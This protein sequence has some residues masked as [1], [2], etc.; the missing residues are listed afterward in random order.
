MLTESEQ[1][2]GELFNNK[3]GFLKDWKLDA[4][5]DQQMVELGDDGRP[6]HM[7]RVWVPK[8]N[9]AGERRGRCISRDAISSNKGTRTDARG[10]RIKS[11]AE[12]DQ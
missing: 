4:N 8:G 5:E 7:D 9:R 10:A 2:D 3:A 1:L 12:N 11:A 6:E